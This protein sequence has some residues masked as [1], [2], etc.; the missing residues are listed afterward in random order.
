MLIKYLKRENYNA[1]E[2][3]HK[4]HKVYEVICFFSSFFKF[5]YV[6]YTHLSSEQK[7]TL[8]QIEWTFGKW[9][10]NQLTWHG[11]GSAWHTVC[12][13]GTYI[14]VC[15]MISNLPIEISSHHLSIEREWVRVSVC[16]RHIRMFSLFFFVPG[17]F[18][19]FM[20]S[21]TTLL[22]CLASNCCAQQPKAAPTQKKTKQNN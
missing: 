6:D 8:L 1:Q 3:E 5:D 12:I 4:Q 10:S 18:C 11:M 21:I 22:F 14:S 2:K 13:N 9:C 20:F 7:K 17:V 15:I 16:F 19:K